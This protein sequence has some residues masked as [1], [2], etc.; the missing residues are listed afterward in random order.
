M[1]HQ[2]YYV[3]AALLVVMTIP[4][5][6]YIFARAR[7]LDQS[8]TAPTSQPTPVQH[9]Y[10][11]VATDQPPPLLAGETCRDGFV[12]LVDGA[13]LREAKGYQG[14]PV[15]CHA[16]HLLAAGDASMAHRAGPVKTWYAY[17]EKLPDGYKCSAVDGPVYRTRV[18]HGATIVE[19]LTRDGV[20]VRCGGERGSSR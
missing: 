4:M 14:G 11:P 7:E 5:Y 10:A 9:R 1:R 13:D 18:E 19:P 15:L 20:M 17:G 2:T 3:I 6:R 16:G 8:A 12:Y